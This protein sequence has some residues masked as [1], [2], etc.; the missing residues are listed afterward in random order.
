MHVIIMLVA[1]KYYYSIGFNKYDQV[2]KFQS[3]NYEVLDAFL[4]KESFEL[5]MFRL[6]VNRFRCRMQ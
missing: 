3:N 4:C 5:F 1:V 6:Y 2:R